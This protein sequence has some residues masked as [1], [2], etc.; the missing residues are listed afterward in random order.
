MYRHG[1][2]LDQLD[3][4]DQ[5]ITIEELVDVYMMADKYDIPKLRHDVNSMLYSLIHAVEDL[6]ASATFKNSFIDCIAR[7]CGP[8]APQLADNTMKTRI[9]EIC[10]ENC[11]SLYQNKNFIQRYARGELFD[12]QS[13][14]DFG[15][16][17]GARLFTSRGSRH[18][19]AD[20]FLRYSSF[21]RYHHETDK[22]VISPILLMFQRL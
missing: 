5:W 17:L 22:Y 3:S 21:M 16:G 2:L 15:I 1:R 13:A 11:V 4:A 18:E 8:D 7:V 19:K 14:A 9:M 12:V 20:S 10:Q 6:S